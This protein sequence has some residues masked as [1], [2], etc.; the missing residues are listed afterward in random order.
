MWIENQGNLKI[1]NIAKKKSNVYFDWFF[2]IKSEQWKQWV[3]ILVKIPWSKVKTGL[4]LI[5]TTGLPESSC[6][7]H[8]VVT[9]LANMTNEENIQKDL[10]LLLLIWTVMHNLNLSAEEDIL[11]NRVSE[12]KLAFLIFFF[13]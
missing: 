5:F 12:K 9:S 4:L 8:W 10:I 3:S 11:V 2:Y 13:Y 7:K 1:R 6:D